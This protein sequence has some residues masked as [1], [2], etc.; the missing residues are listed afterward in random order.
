MAEEPPRTVEEDLQ[1][2][3]QARSVDDKSHVVEEHTPAMEERERIVEREFDQVEDAEIVALEKDV[4]VD[5]TLEE[6]D[7]DQIVRQTLKKR[8]SFSS[9]AFLPNTDKGLVRQVTPRRAIEVPVSMGTPDSAQALGDETWDE[10]FL[11]NREMKTSAPSFAKPTAKSRSAGTRQ[12]STDPKSRRRERQNLTTPPTRT[13]MVSSGSLPSKVPSRPPLT[14]PKGP[15]LRTTV[16]RSRQKQDGESASQNGKASLP[17]RPSP[18]TAT[19]KPANP[20]F[21]PTAPAPFQFHSSKRSPRESLETTPTLHEKLAAKKVPAVRPSLSRPTSASNIRVKFSPTTPVPFQLSS[22]TTRPPRQPTTTVNKPVEATVNPAATGTSRKSTFVPT[23]PV[24]FNLTASKKT[25]ILPDAQESHKVFGELPVRKN[26]SAKMVSAVKKKFVPTTPVPFSLSSSFKRTRVDVSDTAPV[27]KSVVEPPKPII[28]MKKKFV[29]TTP[30]PFSFSSSTKRARVREGDGSNTVMSPTVAS[31][32]RC[33]GIPKVQSKPLTVPKSPNFS[34]AAKRP[35]RLSITTRAPSTLVKSKPLE[36]KILTTPKPFKLHTAV[37]RTSARKA[38]AAAFASE[39]ESKKAFHAKPMP[40]FQN[41]AAVGIKKETSRKPTTAPMPFRFHARKVERVHPGTTNEQETDRKFVARRMPSFKPPTV[42]PREKPK[43][44]LTTPKPFSFGTTRRRTLQPKPIAAQKEEPKVEQKAF[45][46]KARPVPTSTYQLA[47]RAKTQAKHR[48]TQTSGPALSSS[49]RSDKRKALVEASRNRS[50]ALE[51]QK[52]LAELRKQ[53]LRHI[54]DM[55]KVQSP[56]RPNPD[57]I[58]PFQLASVTRSQVYR[59]SFEEKVAKEEKRSQETKDFRA[60]PMPPKH[61]KYTPKKESQRDLTE[62]EPFLLSSVE[63]HKVARQSFQE[64]LELEEEELRKA[65]NFKAQPLPVSIYS[66]P[67][68]SKRLVDSMSPELLTKAAA[69]QRKEFE[70]KMTER[71]K[72]ELA[73]KKALEQQKK[74]EEEEEIRR[75][76]RLPVSEGGLMFKATPIRASLVRTSPKN[77]TTPGLLSMG[78]PSPKQ[79]AEDAIGD[80]V[81]KMSAIGLDNEAKV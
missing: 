21:T 74:A 48:V 56:E 54:S 39:D 26:E 57:D 32:L 41:S 27:P 63:R 58:K 45:K 76:R 12:V 4:M 78:R 72:T 62:P 7:K 53:K 35:P 51:E 2:V 66:S 75:M 59:M 43:S 64:R 6:V 5:D 55:K 47:A 46:F 71:R 10:M 33:K 81:N 67:Q 68:G 20:K 69:E 31:T 42:R 24:P 34:S 36:R 25:R 19:T 23:T 11:P 49:E 22:S 29:P 16:R 8:V 17:P 38:A 13:S 80:L 15:Q 37:S 44:T 28:L 14:V 61:L 9:E 70:R 79:A 50:K 77:A 3:E 73:M 52:R 60:R 1:K 40:N 65:H 30:V 18:A